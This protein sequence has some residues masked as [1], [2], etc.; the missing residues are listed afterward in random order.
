MPVFSLIILGKCINHINIIFSINKILDTLF[1]AFEVSTIS[2]FGC[3]LFIEIGSLLEQLFQKKYASSAYLAK[4]AKNKRFKASA[5]KHKFLFFRD[6]WRGYY[7]DFLTEIKIDYNVKT[8]QTGYYLQ[9][10]VSE[11]LYYDLEKLPKEYLFYHTLNYVAIYKYEP[12]LFFYPKTEEIEI[13]LD[14]MITQVK[15][16]QVIY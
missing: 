13:H 8:Y 2:T 6:C 14:E 9:V 4:V 7:K 5:N 15:N 1:L 3:F 12:F 16:I 10:P 11:H